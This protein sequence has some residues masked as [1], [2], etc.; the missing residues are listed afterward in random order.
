MALPFDT[1]NAPLLKAILIQQPKGCVFILTAHHAIADGKGLTFVLRDLLAIVSGKELG[2]LVFQGSTDDMLGLAQAE[3]NGSG[4]K[5]PRQAI[6]HKNNQ[7]EIFSTRTLPRLD[8]LQFTT[9]LTR[10]IAERAREEE[11]TF[12]GALCAAGILASRDL[13]VPWKEKDLVLVTPINERKAL[14]VQ[15]D[16]TL[17]ITTKAV[18]FD[19]AFETSFWAT[20][21]FAKDELAG[22][23][24]RAY[25]E[26]YIKFFRDITFT[27]RE[28]P[29]MLE[30]MNTVFTQ[31]MMITNLGITD[32][33][34]EGLMFKPRSLW[35]P[36]VISGADHVQT[37]GASTIGGRL[38]LTNLS[39]SP[40]AGILKMMELKLQ[41][42]I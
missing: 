40:I 16:C 19:P 3:E 37:M 32:G 18:V 13:Y 42:A 27:K 5:E 39:R 6:A 4:F 11:T 7:P 15:E 20:A 41:E 12:H 14:K 1:S 17:S 30:V 38:C 25:T 26:G 34:F 24:S 10:Q 31:D 35:G 9:E 23:A 28:L 36:M 2:T 22:T 33:I 21:R 8:R 29:C